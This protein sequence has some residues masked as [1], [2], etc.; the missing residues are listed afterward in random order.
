MAR[1]TAKCTCSKCGKTFEVTAYRRN[2]AAAAEFEAWAAAAITTCR[3]CDRIEKD[4]TVKAK[5]A[6]LGLPGLTGSDKQINWAM[7]IRDEFLADVQRWTARYGDDAA[8]AD[9]FRRQIKIIL[10]AKTA[11]KWWIDLKTQNVCVDVAAV[12]KTIAKSNQDDDKK[13]IAAV[14]ALG[15]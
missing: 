9:M 10:D 4:Q 13:I 6:E 12:G 5:A 14:A 1:A 7:T 15:R 8:S 2:C 11:A 3:D